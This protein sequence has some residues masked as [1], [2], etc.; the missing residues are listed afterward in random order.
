M[1]LDTPTWTLRDLECPTCGQVAL[2]LIACPGCSAVAL[3]CDECQEYFSDASAQFPVAATANCR[4]CGDHALP[5]F[6]AATSE[7]V[8]AAGIAHARYG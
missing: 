1:I 5:A 4:H 2:Q 7:Q 6:T 8:Q 3:A